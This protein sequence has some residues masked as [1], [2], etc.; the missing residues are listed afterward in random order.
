MY[1][2]TQTAFI[3]IHKGIKN[4]SHNFFL[5]FHLSQKIYIYF[6]HEKIGETHASSS[7]LAIQTQIYNIMIFLCKRILSRV[8]E[9]HVWR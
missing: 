1:G 7:I 2:Q 3:T 4:V 5:S 6:S 8:L 9:L